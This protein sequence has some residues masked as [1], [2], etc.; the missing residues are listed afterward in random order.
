MSSYIKCTHSLNEFIHMSCTLTFILHE[1]ILCM[2]SYIQPNFAT[3]EA[4]ATDVAAAA[5]VTVATAGAYSMLCVT[6][7]DD[8]KNLVVQASAP[9]VASAAAEASM[10]AVASAVA[11]A[12]AA[13][14]AAPAVASVEKG[15]SGSPFSF[16]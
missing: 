4:A 6:I 8:A 15:V 16:T 1:T 13:A 11:E 14:V 9:A 2:N 7:A 5:D 12:S 10:A 3:A